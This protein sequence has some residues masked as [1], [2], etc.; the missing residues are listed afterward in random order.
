LPRG[1][2]QEE[3]IGMQSSSNS[4]PWLILLAFASLYVIWGSTYLAI[5]VAIETIPPFLMATTRFLI[6]GAVLY[7]AARLRGVP[8]P[9]PYQWKHAFLVGILLITGGNGVVTFAEKWIDSSMAALIIAINPLVMTLFG[10]W[11]GVQGRPTIGVWL[12]LA[13]GFLGVG[14]L[15]ASGGDIALDGSALGYLCI[16]LAVVSW[17]LGSVFS[18]RNPLSVN[19]WLQSGMQMLSGGIACLLVGLLLG[20]F[21]GFDPGAVSARSWWAFAYLV[22]AGSLVGFT[23][24]VYLLNHCSP[25]TVSSHAYVN[26]VIAVFLGWWMLDEQ[27]TPVGALG[28]GLILASVFLLLRQSRP[29]TESNG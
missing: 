29:K 18:K 21:G 1:E 13:G 7:G 16:L 6:A 11:G 19:P 14:F 8:R 22:I 17:T 26:P 27:L 2:A 10:W 5:K 24:Y 9:T 3:V 15:V 23:S 12:S 25:T 20:E 4:K 28:A